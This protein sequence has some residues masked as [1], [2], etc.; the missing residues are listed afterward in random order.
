MK[1][2]V[3]VLLLACAACGSSPAAPTAVTPPAPQPPSVTGLWQG[4]MTI[5]IVEVGTGLRASNVCTQALTI[6][7]QQNPGFTGTYQLSGGTTTACADSGTVS[8]S[9]QVDGSI[10]V[11]PQSTL[12][13]GPTVCNRIAGNGVFS[14]L[15]SGGTMS[16][17][18]TDTVSCTTGGIT[19][20]A[21]RTLSWAMTKR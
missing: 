15:V 7:S 18:S 21:N 10:A 8:G 11:A 5:A 2:V 13:P 3:G 19:S 20:T 9:I 17:Q 12:P 16:A 14:G 1:W 6:T 4:T